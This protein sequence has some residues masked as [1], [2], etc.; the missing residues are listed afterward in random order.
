VRTIQPD[1]HDS[2]RIFVGI[3]LGGVMRSLDNGQTWEDRKEHSQHDCHSL[4]M[5]PTEK[6]R[7]YEAAGGGF[8]ESSD[9]G[10]TWET[11]ND[12][13]DPYTYLVSVAVDSSDP[14]TIIA[15]AAKNARTA[16]VPE[17]AHT[18]IM[19]RK[20]GEGWKI[21]SNNLPVPDG[22]SAFL[23]ASDTERDKTFY[24]VNNTG[25]YETENGGDH[26]KKIPVEWPSFLRQ[27]R[28]R[29]FILSH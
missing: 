4:T 3:E 26:W 1:I 6:N 28:M 18:V 25:L 11:K 12:G 10:K 13:L 29:A 17:R 20:N 15:S 19:R 5:H 23:L 27:M 24:A 14:E 21:L 2:K 16:Y 7:I 22:S 8:A 9:G